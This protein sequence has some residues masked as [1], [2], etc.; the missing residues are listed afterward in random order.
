MKVSAMLNLAWKNSILR[1]GRMVLI[2]LSVAAVL[3]EILVLEGFLAGSYTQL[4]Q[5]VLRRGGDVMVAQSGVTNF[6][7]TRSILPQQA[8]AA[9]EAI[10][11]VAGTHPLAAIG[12]IY[13]AG[14]RRSPIIVMVYDDAGGPFAMAAG[15]PPAEDG[16]IAVDHAL[17]EKF[18]LSTGDTLTLSD[19]EF[20]ISG[21]TRGES[22]LF[23]PF[24]F[25]NFDTLIDFY[26][27][28]DVASDIAA[29]PLLSFLSVDAAPGTD[30]AD[31]AARITGEVA[32]AQAMLPRDLALNDEE[33]G[34]ELL[35]PVLNL[36]LGLS[37]GIGAMA[38]GMFTFAAVRSRRRSLGVMRALGFTAR[39]IAT[40]VVAEAVV[41]AVAAIPLGILMAVGLAALI[42]RVAPV[43]LLEVLE[44]RAL[45]QTAFVAV[46]LAVLGALAPLRMLMRLDPATAFRE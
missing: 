19:F 15:K 23:T 37:Y 41:T 45:L 42:E 13:E 10:P 35:G 40:G 14:E 34:R 1:P 36:L 12:L 8:R 6:L 26:F 4:R 25:M 31:L 24:A 18:G 43:Y 20:S 38:I 21:I 27:E 11:G 16:S 33:M 17:A 22:A 7:A 3:A 5:T 30:P 9:V 39:H 46:A 28:S 29:F 32:D 44:P 2:I